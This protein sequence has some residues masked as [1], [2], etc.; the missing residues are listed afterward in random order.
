MNVLLQLNLLCNSRGSLF[1]L[2]SVP[3]NSRVTIG[4]E[5]LL[6]G[7]LTIVNDTDSNEIYMLEFL[8]YNWV[9]LLTNLGLNGN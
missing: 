8:V 9:S 5:R 2:R 3:F 6:T 1:S 7:S 4:F